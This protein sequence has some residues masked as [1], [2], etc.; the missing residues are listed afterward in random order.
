MNISSCSDSYSSDLNSDSDSDAD[1]Y[2]DISY[3]QN[4]LD[5]YNKKTNGD[6]KKKQ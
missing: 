1:F 2:P 5:R 4:Q 6:Q 3:S